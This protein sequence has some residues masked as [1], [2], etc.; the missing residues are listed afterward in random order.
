MGPQDNAMYESVMWFNGASANTVSVS[1]F[2]TN[3]TSLFGLMSRTPKTVYDAGSSTVAWVSAQNQFFALATM[4]ATNNLALSLAVRM[5]DLP[6]PSDE[7]IRASSRTVRQPEGLETVL[8]Y[9]GAMLKPGEASELRFNVFA[10]PKEYQTLRRLDNQFNNRI[11]LVMGFGGWYGPI[12]KALLVT[13]IWLNG[14][15]KLSYGL[16]VVLITVA[17]LV[18]APHFGPLFPQFP[19]A[20]D[21]ASQPQPTPQPC[22]PSSWH[23]PALGPA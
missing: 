23:R 7:E 15:V 20:G 12:S 3:T 21:T 10:G 13:M 5:V 14:V 1:Y 17:L 16:I 9:P 8:V 22:C 6:R 18:A 4:P 11:D 2:N 19:R